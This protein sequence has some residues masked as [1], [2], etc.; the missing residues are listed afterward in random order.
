MTVAVIYNLA[1]VVL[2]L[3]FDELRQDVSNTYSIID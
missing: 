3:A 1:V 2:R